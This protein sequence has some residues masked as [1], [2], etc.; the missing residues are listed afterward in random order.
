MFNIQRHELN[1]L[2][3]LSDDGYSDVRPAGS[4]V[5]YAQPRLE[6]LT[7]HAL[8]IALPVRLLPTTPGETRRGSNRM[9]TFDLG[10]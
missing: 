2:A 6:L 5:L 10:A 3:T 1:R 7:Y 4:S 8:H 9:D